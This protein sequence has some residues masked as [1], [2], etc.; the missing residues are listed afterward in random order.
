MRIIVE[1]R[2]DDYK[3]SLDG[4]AD[5]WE[6]DANEFAAIGRLVSRL[7]AQDMP[8]FIVQRN[9]GGFRSWFPDKPMSFVLRGYS[10][11]EGKAFSYRV[12][13]D[14]R[15]T[16]ITGVCDNTPDDITAEK[17]FL[18]DYY[19]TNTFEFITEGPAV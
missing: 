8:G 6:A 5:L 19:R 15:R 11:D 16:N 18:Q 13:I 9:M 14:G 4:R 1:R 17:E 3:A 12:Y 2:S 7:A 10:L